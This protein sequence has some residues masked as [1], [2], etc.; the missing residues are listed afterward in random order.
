[1]YK[2]MIID[3]EEMIRWGIRDLLDW[4]KEGFCFGEDGRDG[5]DGLNKL[6]KYDPDLTLVDIKMPGMG[7]IELIQEARNAGYE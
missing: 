7:G 6:M 5:K 1:M 4:E 2:V 3:D